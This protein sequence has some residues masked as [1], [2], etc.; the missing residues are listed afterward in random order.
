MEEGCASS[1]F[2]PLMT[3]EGKGSKAEKRREK[4]LVTVFLLFFHRLESTYCLNYEEG[5]KGISC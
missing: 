5:Q 2:L 3:Q 4:E 1:Y